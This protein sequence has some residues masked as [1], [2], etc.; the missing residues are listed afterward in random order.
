[1]P[2]F[3]FHFTSHDEVGRDEIGTV[4]P[5]LEAAYLDA[6]EA[7]LGIS[8]EMF[9]AHDDP[10]NDEVEIA[11]ESGRTLM[12]I[13]FSEI[14]RPRQK[15]SVRA[16]RHATDRAIQAC[17]R[18]TLRSRMLWSELQTEFAKTQDTFRSIQSKLAILNTGR[19]Q[20]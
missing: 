13:P 7:V 12:H 9:R 16:S 3:F 6:Y 2:R 5:S 15:V 18:Q 11:D 19:R 4:F 17:Q 8:F 14:L 20:D 1:M 10:T